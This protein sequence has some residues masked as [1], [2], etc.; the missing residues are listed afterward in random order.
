MNFQ[1]PGFAPPGGM[2]RP[3]MMQQPSYYPQHYGY[4]GSGMMPSAAPNPYMPSSSMAV[5]PKPH[6]A[7]TIS[8]ESD[9]KKT[10]GDPIK[11]VNQASNSVDDILDLIVINP[12]PRGSP[13]G[14]FWMLTLLGRQK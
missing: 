1:Q 10:V 9:E 13:L 3:A 8:T 6:I 2:Y 7:A 5:T 14:S 11:E 4:S 12:D